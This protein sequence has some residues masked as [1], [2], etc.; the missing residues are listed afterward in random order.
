VVSHGP[1]DFC[2][3]GLACPAQ[4][5]ARI[6]HFASRHALDIEGLGER[7]VEQLLEARM[8]SSVADLLTLSEEDLVALEGFA[9]LSARNLVEAIRTSVEVTLDRFL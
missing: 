4:L 8:V 9:D 5:K 2:T 6:Q 7:T 3:N 1:L